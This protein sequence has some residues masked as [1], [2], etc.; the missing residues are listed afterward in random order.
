MKK[1]PGIPL[2][3]Y[4]SFCLWEGLLEKVTF[5]LTLE[6]GWEDRRLVRTNLNENAE[7]GDL[8]M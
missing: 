6:R 2:N 7:E 8:R 4:V 3:G 1:T 5:E